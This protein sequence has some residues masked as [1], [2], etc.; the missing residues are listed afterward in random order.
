MIVAVHQP[1]FFP[2]LGLFAKIAKSDV[3]VVLDD[4]APP[5]GGS[6]WLNRVRLRVAGEARWVTAPIDRTRHGDTSIAEVFF[7]GLPWRARL[8]RTL[9]LNYR[10]SDY[11]ESEREWLGELIQFHSNRL[12]S[13]N[14]HAIREIAARVIP[15]VPRIVLA[16][17]FAVE[18]SSTQR[19]VELVEAVGGT[20]YLAGDGAEGYQ[21]VD[22]FHMKGVDVRYNSFIPRPYPQGGLE[23]MPGLSVID[24]LLHLGVPK[25][26]E[27]VAADVCAWRERQGFEPASRKQL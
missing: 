1:T 13:F 17:D 10:G 20:T 2:W 11:Y 15:V 9:D 24:A 26:A 18:S 7:A 5:R 22:L 8:S 23:F 12:V 3:F 6:S 14:L 19:L 21:N 27:M 25:T 4:A 16:S